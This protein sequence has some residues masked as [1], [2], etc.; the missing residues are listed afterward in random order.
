MSFTH[1][2]M[3]K[4]NASLLTK[5]VGGTVLVLLRRNEQ[6]VVIYHYSHVS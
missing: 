5:S 6:T 3:G 4:Q 2:R 1:T